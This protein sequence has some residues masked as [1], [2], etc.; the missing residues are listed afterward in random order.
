VADSAIANT[1]IDN[2]AVNG[3]VEG[4]SLSDQVD[5]SFLAFSKK[6]SMSHDINEVIKEINMIN[7]ADS[8][9]LSSK[10]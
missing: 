6:Y 2:M 1:T 4:F 5:S 8:Y 3:Q 10:N 7:D 9:H